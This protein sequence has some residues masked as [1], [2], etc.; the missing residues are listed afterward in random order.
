MNNAAA[1]DEKNARPIQDDVL[2]QQ[3]EQGKRRVQHRRHGG[4]E[5]HEHRAAADAFGKIILRGVHERGSDDERNGK[6]RH[7]SPEEGM[8]ASFVSPN[9]E[10]RKFTS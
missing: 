4:E 6:E 8:L 10:R 9:Q 2:R 1:D 7:E 3:N 5:P